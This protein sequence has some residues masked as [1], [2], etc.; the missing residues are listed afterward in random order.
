MFCCIINMKIYTNVVQNKV[1]AIKCDSVLLYINRLWFKMPQK[2]CINKHFAMKYDRVL[3][4]GTFLR[5]CSNVK[6][7]AAGLLHQSLLYTF[8]VLDREEL[9]PTISVTSPPKK[10]QSDIRTHLAQ[11]SVS[12]VE[13]R[14]EPGFRLLSISVTFHVNNNMD[15][16]II[17]TNYVLS[18]YMMTNKSDKLVHEYVKM[19]CAVSTQMVHS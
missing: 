13:V 16:S 4:S 8:P 3:L 10:R 6:S 9:C 18:V 17:G 12:W 1:F 19:Q 11:W 14:K 2:C 7:Q 5:H 15:V